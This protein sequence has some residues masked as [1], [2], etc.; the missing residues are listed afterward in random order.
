MV[1]HEREAAGV[2]LERPEAG[3]QQRLHRAG[4]AAEQL[5]RELVEQRGQRRQVV[6]NLADGVAPVG[7]EIEGTEKGS[8]I[9]SPR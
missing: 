7:L 2:D 9:D 8:L 3:V 6:L 1:E 5:E 4:V